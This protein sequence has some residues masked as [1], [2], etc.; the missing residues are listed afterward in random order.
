M[1]T[2]YLEMNAF[3]PY[4]GKQVIDFRLFNAG[5]NVESL[6]ISNWGRNIK[7]INRT[8]CFKGAVP[9]ASKPSFI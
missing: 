9:R 3:G 2:I 4:A 7:S 5:T 8:P 1:K 6:A